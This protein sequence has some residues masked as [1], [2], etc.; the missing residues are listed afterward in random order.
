MQNFVCF[1]G[2]SRCVTYDHTDCISELIPRIFLYLKEKSFSFKTLLW[3]IVKIKW[4]Y[5]C[6][7]MH[8]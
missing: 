4:K 3:H 7:S 6:G 8:I 1:L 5:F 2:T